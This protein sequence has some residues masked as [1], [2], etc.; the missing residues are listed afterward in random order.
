MSRS[1]AIAAVNLLEWLQ[2]SSYGLVSLGALKI[3]MPPTAGRPT[4]SQASKPMRF[5]RFEKMGKICVSH[6]P[7]GVL[8]VVTGFGS[9]CG[10]ALAKHPQV[11]KFSLL[12]ARTEVGTSI[13]S[14]CGRSH[15][16]GNFRTRWQKPADCL[17]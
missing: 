12:Q 5:S 15:C 13:P 9:E 1:Y 7:K 2:V 8:N 4:G 6:L 16:S 10:V 17:S 14:V 3:T 11:D